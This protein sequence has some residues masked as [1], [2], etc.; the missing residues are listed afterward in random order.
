MLGVLNAD[1]S[2]GRRNPA[3]FSAVIFNALNRIA[4]I[5]LAQGGRAAEAAVLAELPWSIT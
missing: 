3:T 1:V 5:R 4:L 2:S